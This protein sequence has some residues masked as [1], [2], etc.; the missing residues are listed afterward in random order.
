MF[1]NKIVTFVEAVPAGEPGGAHAHVAA[2][3]TLPV[4]TRPAIRAR[5]ALAR[6]VRLLYRGTEKTHLSVFHLCYCFQGLHN[7]LNLEF[8]LKKL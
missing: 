5:A 1:H 7:V 6:V 2:V 8:Y 3:G 4:V